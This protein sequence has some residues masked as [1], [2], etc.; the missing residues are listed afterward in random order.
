MPSEL[1]HDE[2]IQAAAEEV[3]KVIRSHC[4]ACNNGVAGV[5]RDGSAE[6]CG[7]CGRLLRAIAWD[8]PSS[9]PSILCA[10]LSRHFGPL[11][12]DKARLDWLENR[13]SAYVED[14]FSIGIISDDDG[15]GLRQCVDAA[16][17][18]EA[19]KEAEDE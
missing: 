10:V 3:A 2:R 12:A 15:R 6:E 1:T 4:P 14:A 5:S 11:L 17:S 8:S 19:A 13:E 18:A 7:Y 16:I 9:E